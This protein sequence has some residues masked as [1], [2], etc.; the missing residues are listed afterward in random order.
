M[1]PM[2]KQHCFMNLFS[3]VCCVFNDWKVLINAGIHFVSFNRKLC[4]NK[5]QLSAYS[6]TI[7]EV[8]PLKQPSLAV[9]NYFLRKFSNIWQKSLAEEGVLFEGHSYHVWR[10][11]YSVILSIPQAQKT[12][13]VSLFTCCYLRSQWRLLREGSLWLCAHNADSD[14]TTSA[15]ETKMS[16]FKKKNKP[17]IS[18][19][20]NR[21]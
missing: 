4:G 13:S 20:R 14:C 12:G 5:A 19:G 7:I 21:K 18:Q 3:Y 11:G 16:F 9:L 8:L 10:R 1:R 6:I 2:M 15:F 17:R